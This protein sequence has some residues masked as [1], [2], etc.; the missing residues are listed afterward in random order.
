M[1]NKPLSNQSESGIKMTPKKRGLGKGP[2]PFLEPALLP[3]RNK[4]WT[5][6]SPM[7]RAPA[8]RSYKAE[9]RSFAYFLAR[10][11]QVSAAWAISPRMRLKTANPFGRRVLSSPLLFVD[12]E[13]SYEIIAAVTVAGVPAS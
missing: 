7:R 9:L 8:V 3:R 11:W 6:S 10:P 1:K 12:D 5:I 2:R 4:S 13:Q